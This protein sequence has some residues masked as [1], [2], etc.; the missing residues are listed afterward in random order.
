[1]KTIFPFAESWAKLCGGLS[2]LEKYLPCVWK[3]IDLIIASL[4]L[5]YYYVYVIIMSMLLLSL[6][7]YHVYVVIKSMLLLC[8]CCYYVYVTIKS[9]LL[10]KSCNAESIQRYFTVCQH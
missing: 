7:Y 8:P 9:I 4:S 10:R 6:C 1:M 5:C 2:V 3:H